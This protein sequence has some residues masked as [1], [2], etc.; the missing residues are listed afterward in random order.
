[1]PRT[2]L[3]SL[4]LAG[5]EC[6]LALQKAMSRWS[7]ANHYQGYNPE[8]AIAGGDTFCV[9]GDE[10]EAQTGPID[11]RY[12]S[13]TPA[14]SVPLTRTPILAVLLGASFKLLENDV[15]ETKL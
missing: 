1:M 3:T 13:V 11:V 15:R 9:D 6:I 2:F 12:S 10:S 8:T 14:S 5:F 7:C 4:D